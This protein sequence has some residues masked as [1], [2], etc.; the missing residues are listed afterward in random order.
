MP[1][2]A[3]RPLIA[4]DAVVLDT[5]T[6]GLDPLKARIVQIGAVG[7]R[8]GVVDA[9]PPFM[10]LVD[11]G[12]PIP[13]AVTAIH[14]I[15]DADVAGAAA[16][17]EA[18]AAFEAWRAGR[19]LIGHNLGFD[20]AV[21]RRECRL[22]GL[23]FAPPPALDTRL[24]GEVC[25]P[26]L[27]GFSLEVL[28]GRLGIAVDRAVRHDAVADARLA[29]ELFVALLPHLKALGVRTVAEAG[30]AS[31]RLTRSLDR[32]A[33]AGWEEPKA[34]AAAAD[35]EALRRID[36]YPFRHRARD[37]M[38]RPPV[39][40]TPATSLIA[41]ARLMAE[42]RISSVFVS[43]EAEPRTAEAAILTERDVMRAIAREGAAML[44]WPVSEV[45]SRPL[46]AIGE[47][48]FLYRA[49][50]R[51]DRLKIRHLAVADAAGCIVGALTARDLLKVRASDALS[52]GDA[53]EAATGSAE[54]AAAFARMPA[55]ARRLIEEEVPARQV[56]AVVSDEIAA[57]TARA[58]RDAEAVLV[59]EGLGPAPIPYAVLVLGSVGRGESLLAADQ[60]NAVV[61]AVA[62]DPAAA[63]RWFGRFGEVMASGL[64]AVGVAFC[65]GGVM[66]RNPAFRGSLDDWRRRIDGW[67]GRTRPDDLL[68]VDIFFDFRAVHGDH[69]LAATLSDEAF[70]AARRAPLLAKLL[71]DQIGDLASP[72]TFFG[73]L[74][75]E[76][77]RI[78]LKKSGLFP[79]VAGAR[80]LALRHDIRAR[81]TRER[82]SAIRE[83]A[84]GGS[85]DIEKWIDAHGV[86]L[87][88][89]L[90]Q[91][92]AD[93]AAG[94]PPGSW[95]DPAI[96]L[97]SEQAR[98]KAALS[99]LAHVGETVRD[100]LFE[101]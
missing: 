97:R 44:E 21:L 93:L 31:A 43:T 13:A 58:A 80:C 62:P 45:A 24:L 30:E 91:Q 51:M 25:F 56:A 74:R 9:G 32:L 40:V 81:S 59:A 33:G 69:G 72:L 28:A 7:I 100:L 14:G 4:V 42:K 57:L 1:T 89:V 39:T 68:A 48:D 61:T 54:L 29:A 6:T 65:K 12:V 8:H 27:P 34:V 76:N 101:S 71:A 86:V 90:R 99:A 55:V 20:L 75:T 88:A 11:P 98:L 49:I 37:I 46:Q 19:P 79:V 84:I 78:D 23:A 3:V 52:L 85:E 17:A 95:V 5:E 15:G 10:R 18:F 50:G 64:D 16:F 96:L 67:I 60:D 66:A 94:I 63:D 2:E 47:D 41:A 35:N 38:G 26:T 77:G 36:A 82:L 53:V 70:R 22:A 83:R 73:G 87:D 92:L